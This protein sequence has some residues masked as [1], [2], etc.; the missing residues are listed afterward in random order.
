MARR[1]QSPTHRL[2]SV[3]KHEYERYFARNVRENWKIYFPLLSGLAS[4]SLCCGDESTKDET[5]LS[6]D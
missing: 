5:V 6:A 4:F 3:N 2:L 1:I